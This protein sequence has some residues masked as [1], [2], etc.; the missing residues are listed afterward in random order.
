MTVLDDYDKAL[1][2]A[3]MVGPRGRIIWQRAIPDLKERLSE[4]QN[5][6]C[7][8]CGF[9]MNESTH[10]RRYP[11]FEHVIPVSTGGADLPDNIVI[12]CFD[13]NSS[14]SSLPAG[15]FGPKY[16]KVKR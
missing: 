5:H 13:C 14:R 8:Y 9:R 2:Q 10:W 4:A 6:R 15:Q 7:C 11:T 16:S 1:A 3:W 12:A